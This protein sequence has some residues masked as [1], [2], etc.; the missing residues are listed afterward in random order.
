M[1]AAAV[2]THPA[3]EENLIRGTPRHAHKPGDV[4]TSATGH[5]R[6]RY[7]ENFSQCL[8]MFQELRS[9][10][11]DRCVETA[12]S[13][14]SRRGRYVFGILKLRRG[15]ACTT[16]AARPIDATDVIQIPA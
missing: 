2:P 9:L 5:G 14:P 7:R 16:A 1:C 15:R 4:E 10:R 6:R 11:R 12:V 8:G 13:R 3:T